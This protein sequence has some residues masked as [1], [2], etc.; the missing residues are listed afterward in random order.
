MQPQPD[1][2]NPSAAVPGEIEH[3]C[4]GYGGMP[5]P[6]SGEKMVRLVAIKA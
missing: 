3:A 2:Q 1:W 6:A 5:L 4:D